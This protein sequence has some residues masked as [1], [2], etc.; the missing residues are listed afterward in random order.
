MT[1]SWLWLS[2]RPSNG[3]DGTREAGYAMSRLEEI[4]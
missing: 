3:F 1:T 2:E 4:I